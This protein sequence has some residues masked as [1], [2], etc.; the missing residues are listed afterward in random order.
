MF[1]R[2]FLLLSHSH[3]YTQKERK[4]SRVASSSSFEMLLIRRQAMQAC[5]WRK[6]KKKKNCEYKKHKLCYKNDKPLC[7]HKIMS[8]SNSLSI[9]L[10]LPMVIAIHIWRQGQGL[11]TSHSMRVI[12]VWLSTYSSKVYFILINNYI[13]S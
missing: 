5:E 7:G 2:I 4:V 1:L 10:E 3:S 12:H 6:K 9:V 13:T 11:N 8:S